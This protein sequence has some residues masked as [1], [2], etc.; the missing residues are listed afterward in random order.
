M[1]SLF[2]DDIVA[3]MKT[4]RNQGFQLLY[5]EKFLEEF[6]A[7]CLVNHPKKSVLTYEIAEGWIYNYETTS[8][9]QLDKRVRTMKPSWALSTKCW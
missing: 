9:Q 5:L 8:K 1:H 7:Y 4:L 6:E 2:Y 3:V